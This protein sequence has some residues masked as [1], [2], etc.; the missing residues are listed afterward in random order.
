MAK[1]QSN[2]PEPGIAHNIHIQGISFKYNVEKEGRDKM[3]RPVEIQALSVCLDNLCRDKNKLLTV[4]G[5]FTYSESFHICCANTKRHFQPSV[6]AS[7]VTCV[8]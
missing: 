6:F 4:K 7:V 3:W 1:A 8:L 2:G 5:S